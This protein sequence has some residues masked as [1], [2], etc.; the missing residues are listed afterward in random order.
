M[1]GLKDLKLGLRAIEPSEQSEVKP[2]SC[3]LKIKLARQEKALYLETLLRKEGLVF[4]KEATTNEVVYCIGGL[5]Q[6]VAVQFKAKLTQ[7]M[8]NSPASDSPSE[9][10]PAELSPQSGSTLTSQGLQPLLEGS[11]KPNSQ[12]PRL[13]LYEVCVS[14]VHQSVGLDEF[15][16]FM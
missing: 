11:M 5:S 13:A 8:A 3:S 10:R 7:F 1:S 15:K 2:K 9:S 14:G 12:P 4:M 6:E 16:E